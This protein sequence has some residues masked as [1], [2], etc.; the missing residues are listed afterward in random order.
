MS[1]NDIARRVESQIHFDGCDITDDIRPFILSVTYTDNEEDEAD[2]LQIQL[3]DAD[4]LWQ[5]EY[6]NEIISSVINGTTIPS[7]SGGS[8]GT[9]SNRYKVTAQN[10]LKVRSRPGTQYY[11]YGTLAYGKIITVASISNGWAN[12]TYDGKNAYCSARFLKKVSSGNDDDNPKKENSSSGEWEYKIGDS[13][14]AN[15]RPQYSSYGT[16]GSPGSLVSNYKGTITHLNLRSSVPYP[17]CVG[18]LGWFS[19]SEVTLTGA[20]DNTQ[21]SGTGSKGLKIQAV[22]VRRNWE[23]DGKDELLD[24]GQFEL[25]SITAQSPPSTVTI[26]ATSLPYS[27]TVRKTKKNK[28]WENFTLSEILSEIADTNNMGYMFLCEENPLYERLEQFNQTDIGFL[29]LLCHDA[30]LSLKCTNNILVAFD[31]ADNES[32]PTVRTFTRGKGY[33]SYRFS[34]NENNTYTSC[35]VSYTRSDGTVISGTAY[36][37]DYD[38]DRDKNQCLKLHRKVSSKSAARKLAYK[39]LRLYNKFEYEGTFTLPF[40]PDLYAGCTVK[41]DETF[42]LWQGKYVVK[43][44]RH[45]IGSS[46]TTQITVRKIPR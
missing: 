41:V 45:T 27:S 11:V 20:A 19:K 22:F 44:A 31:Q 25:D 2:D 6:L 36:V 26:K 21:P 10:G 15:G 4:G 28:V 3:Q 18:S 24:C 23:S 16:G 40:S 42:G 1:R 35:K 9:T 34:T 14:I 32:N 33:T 12:F 29:Q 38:E 46:S 37:D 39:M 17:I 13:V 30:G 8:N 43:T 5:N 7:S